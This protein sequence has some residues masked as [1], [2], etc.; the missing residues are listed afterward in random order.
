[1]AQA[2][3]S[4][5]SPSAAQLRIRVNEAAM[6]S[7]LR[8]A[9]AAAVLAALATASTLRG[10]VAV[11]QP[12]ANSSKAV[13]VGAATEAEVAA[14]R[15]KLEKVAAGLTTMLD[16]KGPLAHSK[17]AA[18]MRTF[19]V[20]LNKVLQETKDVSEPRK[21]LQRLQQAQQSV[22]VLVRDI[23]KQQ[24]QLMK[25]GDQ[26]E[27]SLLLGVL[28]TR[29]HEAMAKQMEV[30]K[31]EEFRHLPVVVAVLAANN[32]ATPLYQQVGAYLDAHSSGAS[33]VV[34]KPSKVAGKP[35][36]S[37]IV[38]ALEARLTKLEAAE[39]RRDVLHRD[40][41][42]KMEEAAIEQDKKKASTLAHRIRLLKRSED[43][44]FAKEA[45]L[46]RKDVMSLKE[47][48]TAIKTG[49]VKALQKAQSALQ[50]LLKVMEAQSGG[51]LVLIQLTHRAE[52]LDCPYCAAQCVE[53]CHTAGK[54]YSACLA[55]C[56]DAG[57]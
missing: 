13:A 23:T 41:M 47:A 3:G 39:S 51:F 27:E 21:A 56:A 15:A 17:V 42:K 2:L 29:Q 4:S 40:Q 22:Q 9:V 46:G 16:P 20:E 14:L 48:V 38:T 50:G 53:K 26:Q 55:D 49:D 5:L 54:P 18:T 32:T 1:L 24:V 36:V 31:S 45:A 19:S 10:P 12:R 30:L 44:K 25:Q 34:P 6:A 7:A 8:M 57:K 28:L 33:A 37:G 52:G 43:R 35:D 11:A